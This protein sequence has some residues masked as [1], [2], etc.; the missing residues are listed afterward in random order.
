MN[1]SIKMYICN[2]TAELR[3]LCMYK[4]RIEYSCKCL[5][6]TRCT[7]WCFAKWIMCVCDVACVSIYRQGWRVRLNIFVVCFI[8]SCILQTT[9]NFITIQTL[10]IV[11]LLPL[12][13]S[14]MLSDYISLNVIPHFRRG[15][16]LCDLTDFSLYC[17]L[18][19]KKGNF[20]FF[21]LEKHNFY[22]K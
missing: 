4:C 13:C 22:Q 5:A 1:Q 6:Y 15:E 10:C 20:I 2:R 8:V 16:T 3:I 18:K 11:V 17:K 12:S 19:T 7:I 21:R 14:S 9:F